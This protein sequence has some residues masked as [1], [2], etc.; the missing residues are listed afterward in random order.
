MVLNGKQGRSLGYFELILIV[1][2]LFLVGAAWVV[3]NNL[4][5][6]INSAFLDQ[7]EILKENSTARETLEGLEARKSGFFDG[8]FGLVLL[9][10]FLL[11]GISAWYSGSNPV[12]FIVTILLIIVVLVVPLFLGE[13]WHDLASSFEDSSQ[14]PL[15]SRVMDNYLLVSVVFVLFIL[16]VMY[17]KSRVD[18]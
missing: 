1:V 7:P 11:G 8:A 10:M 2:V 16:G 12:F 6:N 3:T 17:Y 5:S 15:M 14:M 9:A 4:G 18:L 13:A